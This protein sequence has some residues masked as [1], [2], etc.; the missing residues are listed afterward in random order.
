MATRSDLWGLRDIA[1][2]PVAAG[3]AEHGQGAGVGSCREESGP[4]TSPRAGRWHIQTLVLGTVSLCLVQDTPSRSF[5]TFPPPGH[6]FPGV[7]QP[8]TC[9]QLYEVKACSHSLQ[10]GPNSR[11]DFLGFILHLSGIWKKKRLVAEGTACL[12][13]LQQARRVHLFPSEDGYL[14]RFSSPVN[15]S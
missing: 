9:Q 13:V 7:S 15:N 1:R 12:K 6:V 2:A 14:E 3:A 11:A 4:G 10:H 5:G 8:H